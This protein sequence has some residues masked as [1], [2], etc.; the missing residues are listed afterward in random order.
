MKKLAK[1]TL[2]FALGLVVLFAQ[3][4]VY[5]LSK[6]ND[7]T[8]EKAREAVESAGPDDWETLAKSAEM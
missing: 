7:K 8:I 2:A 1:T 6:D 4:D 5:A 3:S